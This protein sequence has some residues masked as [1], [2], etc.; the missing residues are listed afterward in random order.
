[1]LRT[2]VST[3]IAVVLVAGVT[4]AAEEKGQMVRGTLVKCELD[5]GMICVL[6]KKNRQDEGT[7]TEFKVTDDTKFVIIKGRN[8]KVT[9]TKADATKDDFKKAFKENA[10]VQVELGADGKTVKTISTGGGRRPRRDS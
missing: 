1:M 8:D 2:F 7:K 9:L 5:K 3:A 10:R 6:V 4:L